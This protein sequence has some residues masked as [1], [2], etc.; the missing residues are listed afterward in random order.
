MTILFIAS[1]RLLF[2]KSIAYLKQRDTNFSYQFRIERT[3]K[4]G[5]YGNMSGFS[6]EKR[7]RNLLENCMKLT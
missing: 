1:I 7:T 3:T 6:G 5:E 4:S 2:R